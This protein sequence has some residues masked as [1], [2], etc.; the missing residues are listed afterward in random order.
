MV[1]WRLVAGEAGFIG[2]GSPE[3]RCPD[4]MDGARVA[5]IAAVGKKR[6]RMRE[7]TFAVQGLFLLREVEPQPDESDHHDCDAENQTPQLEPAEIFVVLQVVARAQRFGGP[8]SS[9][10]GPLNF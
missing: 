2:N 5:Q 3:G 9:H 6:M 1:R 4:S 10:F 8:N 7:W